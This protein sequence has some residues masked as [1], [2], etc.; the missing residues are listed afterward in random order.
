MSAIGDSWAAGPAAEMPPLPPRPDMNPTPVA[1]A[2]SVLR[3]ASYQT[4]EDWKR[5]GAVLGVVWAFFFLLTI[6]G[7]LALSHYRK[8]K[9]DE[10]ATPFGLIWWGYGFS[11]LLLF[12]VV[13]ASV[14]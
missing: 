13:V 5:I 14:G 8:W 6:P 1:S 4:S 7:W 3:T 2:R 10:I 12:M 9:R 11:T